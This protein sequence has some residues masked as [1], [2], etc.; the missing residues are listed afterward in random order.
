MGGNDVRSLVP[1]DGTAAMPRHWRR[2]SAPPTDFS[3]EVGQLIDI[4][5]VNIVVTGVP[6]VGL[7]PRYDSN[8]DG[9]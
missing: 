7:I 6:D 9:R 5:V 8:G 3:E 2:C 1:S 4:G